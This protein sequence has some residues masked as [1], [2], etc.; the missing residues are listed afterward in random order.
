V[1]QRFARDLAAAVIHGRP[2]D[3]GS[4]IIR[5]RGGTPWAR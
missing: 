1:A 4:Y 3:E 2:S 5:A